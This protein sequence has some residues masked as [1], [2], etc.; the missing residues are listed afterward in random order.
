MLAT[1]ASCDQVI[2]EISLYVLSQY[3]RVCF[4]KLKT[5]F[6]EIRHSW[7]INE[8]TR[9]NERIFFSCTLFIGVFFVCFSIN[10]IKALLIRL[11]IMEMAV[12]EIVAFV[13][14]LMNHSAI[15]ILIMYSSSDIKTKVFLQTKKVTVL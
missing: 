7:Q 4:V 11:T 6:R 12:Q 3:V 10:C 5:E 9:L 14:I 2:F 15:M 8:I 1:L 13:V